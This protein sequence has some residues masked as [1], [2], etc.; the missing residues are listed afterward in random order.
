[1]VSFTFDAASFTSAVVI[2]DCSR[3]RSG[4]D[5]GF[6]LHGDLGKVSA[7]KSQVEVYR[8]KAKEYARLI[9]LTKSLRE[10]RRYRKLV[11]MYWPLA[12]GEKRE[13]IQLK[14]MGKTIGMNER[15]E[16]V[17]IIETCRDTRPPTEAIAYKGWSRNSFKTPSHKRS[18]LGNALLLSL[19]RPAI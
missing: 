1:V 15:Q 6:H 19:N 8:A 16:P 10:N 9:I 14:K 18:G 2:I 13:S 7:V 12:L 5:S 3:S 4:A 17:R 11:E